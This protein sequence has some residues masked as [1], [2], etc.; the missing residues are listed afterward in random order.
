[1]HYQAYTGYQS[2]QMCIRREHHTFN[3]IQ[4]QQKTHA[5]S[6]N[7]NVHS[8]CISISVYQCIIIITKRNQTRQ[9]KNCISKAINGLHSAF[10]VILLFFGITQLASDMVVLLAHWTVSVMVEWLQAKI[11]AVCL[12]YYYDDDAAVRASH[13]TT[14]TYELSAACA[15]RK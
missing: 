13:A 1:M 15:N 7:C 5:I 14:N 4:Q 6:L 8:Q 2:L 9:V 10:S 12:A 11:Y 3:R